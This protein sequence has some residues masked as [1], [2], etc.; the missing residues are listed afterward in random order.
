MA[1]IE[2]AFTGYFGRMKRGAGKAGFPRF[3]AKSR[4]R[5]FGLYEITGLRLDLRHQRIRLKGMDRPIRLCPDRSLPEDARLLGATFTKVGR[6]WYVALIF[7]SAG[8]ARRNARASSWRDV[9][10]RVP[11]DVLLS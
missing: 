10:S 5:S 8:R 3:M 4:W 11:G 1:R 2:D 7:E 9:P 6:G